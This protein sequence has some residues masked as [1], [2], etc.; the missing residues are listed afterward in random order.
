M[1]V[2]TGVYQSSE[3]YQTYD[4][5]DT[6]AIISAHRVP[7]R[8]GHTNDILTLI[9][10]NKEQGKDYLNGI[11]ALDI[12]L[13]VVFCI[14]CLFIL[15][16]K[17]FGQDKVGGWSGQMRPLKPP[18]R[19][20]DYDDT[21]VSVRDRRFVED[22]EE[23]EHNTQ[24]TRRNHKIAK[25]SVVVAGCA[26]IVSAI[27]MSVWGVQSLVHSGQNTRETIE[28]IQN[29]TDGGIKIIDAVFEANFEL[30][31]GIRALSNETIALCPNGRDKICYD[32]A[33]PEDSILCD[34][35]WFQSNG[36]SSLLNDS[37]LVDILN[38]V[39]EE[40]ADIYEDLGDGKEDLQDFYQFL[41]RADKSVQSFNWA[42]RVARMF[43]IS[44]A[45]L[46]AVIVYGV[47]RQPPRILYCMS[48]FVT[49]PLFCLLVFLC[50][51]FSLVFVVG[52][53]TVADLC[54][55]T[56]DDRILA[57]LHQIESQLKGHMYEFGVYFVSKCPPALNP[58]DFELVSNSLF[59]FATALYTIYGGWVAITSDYVQACGDEGL[60]LAAF[61]IVRG[62][63]R[64]TCDLGMIMSTLNEYFKCDNFFPVYEQLVYETMC[65][66]GSSGFL[67]LGVSQVVI[68]LMSLVILTARCA[69][70]PLVVEEGEEKS[71]EKK[72]G[73]S[74]SKEEHEEAENG[75]A[76][77]SYVTDLNGVAPDSDVDAPLAEVEPLKESSVAPLESAI[78]EKTA[79]KD[80]STCSPVE[81][82]PAS[83]E[84]AIEEKSASNGVTTKSPIE[85]TSA[86]QESG[87]EENTASN[88]SST[89]SPVE[90]L[91]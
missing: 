20:N 87:N 35:D 34:W 79:S 3:I 58:V 30:T 42:Y 28:M 49:I 91:S 14:W 60:V 74:V 8:F 7:W 26:I 11:F 62:F 72:D 36:S 13:F 9:E 32:G 17:C 1:E 15:A 39:D 70:H 18:P 50:F 69:F 54:Y 85:E 40:L 44:L 48:C 37:S 71:M 27:S 41:D 51:V 21:D 65:Y 16:L 45:V 38:L 90:Q 33:P 84:S 31:E 73:A 67:A 81:E 66:N 88:D 4:F 86:P 24:K 63:A 19:I 53:I 2:C 82:S 75:H 22:M 23:W 80:S 43:G 29:L 6:N 77:L 47:V 78:E 59:A 64:Q 52:T 12:T 5:E 68:V 61:E 89:N 76:D 25:V 83:P 10:G 55:G 57:I 56:P 46:C